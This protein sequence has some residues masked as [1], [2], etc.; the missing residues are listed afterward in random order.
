M[1]KFKENIKEKI[2]KYIEDNEIWDHI[3]PIWSIN[4]HLDQE[5]AK[6]G[7]SLDYVTF[8]EIIDEMIKDSEYTKEECIVIPQD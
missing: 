7:L 2:T 5:L 3:V 4:E 6:E 1:S 8:L